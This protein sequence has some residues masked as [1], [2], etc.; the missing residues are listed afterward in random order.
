MRSWDIGAVDADPHTPR[1][2]S[3]SAAA[4][5]VALTLEAGESLRDHEVHE[6][7][8]LVVIS[9]QIEVTAGTE[10]PV[11]GEPGMLFEF[12]PQERHEVLGRSEARLLL[13]LA[14]WPGEGHPGA[15]TLEQKGQARHDAAEH[16]ARSQQAGAG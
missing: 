7:A 8:W 2:L 5:V 13:L 9:G 16:V 10:G 15:M 3:S 12:A 11:P 1:I 4:R 14:P 6:R